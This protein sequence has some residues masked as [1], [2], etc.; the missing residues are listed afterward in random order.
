MTKSN[1]LPIRFGAAA[2]YGRRG[3]WF[4]SITIQHTIADPNINNSYRFNG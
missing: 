2:E 4:I 1:Q 3:G